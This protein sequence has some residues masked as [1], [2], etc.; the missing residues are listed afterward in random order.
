MRAVDLDRAGDCDGKRGAV[1]V[2]KADAALAARVCVDDE[3]HVGE[4][5]RVL[6]LRVTLQKLRRGAEM[7][8]EIRDLAGDHAGILE[9]RHADRH[10]EALL[11]QVDEASSAEISSWRSGFS[12]AKSIS[13]WPTSAST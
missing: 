6:Q 8:A 12:R 13:D 10:V 7:N 5:G 9:L 11:D 2:L 1:G 4:I 3:R